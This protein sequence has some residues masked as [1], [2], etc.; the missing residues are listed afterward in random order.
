MRTPGEK[1]EVGK[2]ISERVAFGNKYFTVIERVVETPDGKTREPQLL[3]D[4]GGKRF[5]VAVAITPESRL[6]L[7][8][9]PKYGQMRNMLVVPTGAVKKGETLEQAAD[10][11]FTEETGYK[12]ENWFRLRDEPVIDFADKTDGGEHYFFF[13]FN[14][15]KVAEPEEF[16]E[17]VLLDFITAEELVRGKS[18]LRLE[19]AMSLAA[20]YSALDY[21]LRRQGI[22]R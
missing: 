22:R 17:I 6:V 18:E 4:R 1:T 12:A 21:L 2:I 19:I 11:E 15:V 5:A 14:A 10:R 7:I 16:R 9:E 13:G 8:R 20:L 3:W